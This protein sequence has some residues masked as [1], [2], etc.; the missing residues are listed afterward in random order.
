MCLSMSK[1]AD[2]IVDEFTASEVLYMLHLYRYQTHEV[3]Q[4][5]QQRDSSRHSTIIHSSTRL[6][7]HEV[8]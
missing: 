4:N 2:V 1:S 7:L 5:N 8:R 6:D 3:S